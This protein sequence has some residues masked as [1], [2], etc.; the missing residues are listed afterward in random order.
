MNNRKF[1][2]ILLVIAMLCLVTACGKDAPGTHNTNNND[3][4]V[5]NNVDPNAVF[6]PKPGEEDF[7]VVV[8]SAPTTASDETV[9]YYFVGDIYSRQE[10]V[11]V[12]ETEEAAQANFVTVSTYEDA[13]IEGNTVSFKF[14]SNAFQGMSKEQV[15]AYWQKQFESSKDFYSTWSVGIEINGEVNDGSFDAKAVQLVG[16]SEAAN[17]TVTYYFINN[18]YV[19]QRSEIVYASEADAQANF[20]TVSSYEEAKLEGS[21]ISFK[22]ISATFKGYT[23]EQV[24]EYWEKQFSSSD[25]FYANY[26]VAEVDIPQN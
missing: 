12:Y 23:R 25:G 7:E 4:F 26:T 17:E 20:N 10:S 11:I 14:V 2:A 21:T 13:K 24:L 6:T 19:S 1:I 22:F 5:S 15:V 16:K 18:K 9:T 8:L 3:E